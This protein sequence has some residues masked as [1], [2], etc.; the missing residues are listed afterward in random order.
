MIKLIDLILENI[1]SKQSKDSLE[2]VKNKE[3]I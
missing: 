2:Y 3:T 1:S